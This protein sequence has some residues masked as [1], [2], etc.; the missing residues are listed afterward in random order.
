MSCQF[1]VVDPSKGLCQIC[2]LQEIVGKLL[3]STHSMDALIMRLCEI[4]DH[5]D[6]RYFLLKAL[7]QQLSQR[8]AEVSLQTV[9]GIFSQ[10]F[11]SCKAFF[12]HSCTSI[13][14]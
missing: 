1:F 5:D 3:S 4:T 14:E 12:S 13:T 7:R 10:I 8:P 9:V 11:Y 2:A 6:A